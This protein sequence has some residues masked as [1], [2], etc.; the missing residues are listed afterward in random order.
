MRILLLSLAALALVACQPKAAEP[1]LS[2]AET[3]GQDEPGAPFDPPPA[4]KPLAF[5]A[6][7]KTA[8]S[9]TGNITLQALPPPRPNAAPVMR[10]EAGNG[11][12][13]Q[14]DLIPGGAAQAKAVK[15][16]DIF[17]AP[18]D[19]S[20]SPPNGSPSV[21]IHAVTVET[22]PPTAPN[23]GFCGKERTGFIAMAIPLDAG[24]VQMMSLAAFK[25]DQWPPKAETDLCGTFNYVLPAPPQ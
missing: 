24:G 23:G 6:L 5:E 15:W 7:S 25:G 10:L 21:D 18:I 22:V 13:Y 17:N 2:E 19:T 8:A 3:F 11:I 14:T 20:D 4:L 9:F 1:A 16:S 12:V